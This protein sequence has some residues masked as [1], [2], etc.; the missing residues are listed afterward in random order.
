MGLILILIPNPRTGP[1]CNGATANK[2]Q[3]LENFSIM[4]ENKLN[5]MHN[6]HYK[7]NT[8]AN[9]RKMYTNQKIKMVKQKICEK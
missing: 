8:A 6:I 1:K 2:Y 7:Q 9:A 4:T 3:D 5:I